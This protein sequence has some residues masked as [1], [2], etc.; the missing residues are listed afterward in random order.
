MKTKLKKI[1]LRT[2]SKIYLK[3]LSSEYTI[4]ENNDY[5]HYMEVGSKTFARFNP[6]LAIN[7]IITDYFSKSYAQPIITNIIVDENENYI[8]ITL[9]TNRV[10]LLIGKNGDTFDE[11]KKRLKIMFNKEID[12]SL[13][14]SPTPFGFHCDLFHSPGNEGCC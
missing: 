8:E 5:R 14:E 4:L 13:R 7:L 9:H 10:G 12:L 3:M 2:L 11:L 1:I 6:I